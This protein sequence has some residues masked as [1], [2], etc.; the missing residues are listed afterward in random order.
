MP[1]A[2]E[3]AKWEQPQPTVEEVRRNLGG[4]SVSDDELILRFI[5]QEEKEIQAMRA[6]GPPVEYFTFSNPLVTLIH[7]LLRKEELGYVHVKKGDL[8]LTLR[9]N[10]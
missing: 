3:L 6:A 10:P 2:K 9:K 4:P 5:I 8:A 1:R 7:E